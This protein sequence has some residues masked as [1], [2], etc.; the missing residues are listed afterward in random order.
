MKIL[1]NND[2]LNEASLSTS[3]VGFIPT[4]GSLHKGHISL[5]KRSKIECK[6]TIVSIFVNPTQ[7]NKKIG[8][9]IFAKVVEATVLGT[10]IGIGLAVVDLRFSLSIYNRV[11]AHHLIFY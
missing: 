2:D 11:F 10:I 9:Y 8:D 3:N 1:L 4:M 5:I 6:K 7:F